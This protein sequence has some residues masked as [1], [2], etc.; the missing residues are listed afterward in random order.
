MPND[1]SD[2]TLTLR[3]VGD[4]QIMTQQ[5]DPHLFASVADDL[6][7]VDVL[8]GNCEWPYTDGVFDYHPVEAHLNDTFDGGDM[9]QPGGPAC[10]AAMGNAGFTVMSVA[11][12]H[13][14]HAGYR[15]FARTLELLE[16]NGIAPVGGGANLAEARKA[17]I[18]ERNGRRLAFIAVTSGFLPGTQAG[19]RTPGVATLRRHSYAENPAWQDWGINPRLRTLA[20]R[21]DLNALCRTI[22]EARAGADAVILSCHWGILEHHEAID[23]FQKESARACIDAGADLIVGQGPLAIRGFETYRGK[24]VLYNM[25]KFAMVQGWSRDD[26]PDDLYFMSPEVLA[27][28]RRGLALDVALGP[29]GLVDLTLRPV[30]LD[31][32][33]RPR[34]LM[35]DEPGFADVIALVRKRTEAAGLNGRTDNTGRII[36]A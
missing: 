16:E 31:A 23:D 27:E 24:A 9:L 36:M 22:A 6:S 25:G 26:M 3:A 12:N 20:D 5:P 30:A 17:V 35:Q 32:A 18:V 28:A 14:M 34:F 19:R 1:I 8:F 11:N 33:G 15:A 21:D 2:G 29:E 10:V 7:R 13:S 4:L